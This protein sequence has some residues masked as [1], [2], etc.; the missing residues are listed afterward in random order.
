M[1]AREAKSDLVCSGGDQLIAAKHPSS[2][3]IQARIK[4]LQQHW[5]V[6]RELVENR[7][8]QLEDALEAYQVNILTCRYCQSFLR[9]ETFGCGSTK[10]ADRYHFEA[11]A[12]LTEEQALSNWYHVTSRHANGSNLAD[13]YMSES[14]HILRWDLTV[15]NVSVLR[16]CQRSWILAERAFSFG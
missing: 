15:A 14:T 10:R 4:S 3:D 1:K 9:C 13:Q 6:L 11:R 5:K 12:C 8:K 7:R 2:A 16:G